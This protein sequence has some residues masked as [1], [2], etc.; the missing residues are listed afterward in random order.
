M[1]LLKGIREDDI[2]ALL[3]KQ[4]IENID[5]FIVVRKYNSFW[6]EIFK[7]LISNLYYVMDST[8]LRVLLA[9]QDELVVID[10]NW[11]LSGDYKNL[12]PKYTKKF[13]WNEVSDFRVEDGARVT[14]LIWTVNGKEET[15]LI[16]VAKPGV[17]TFNPEHL[18]NFV[19]IVSEKIKK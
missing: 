3:Q 9:T 10:P 13:S 8:S 6:K 16:D 19:S 14:K 15:W 2:V 18:R 5:T 12:N 11:T 4:N 7:L 17:W 1:S